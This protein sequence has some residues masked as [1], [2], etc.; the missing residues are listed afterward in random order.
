MVQITRS[1]KVYD[2][3]I[4]GSGAAGGAAAK[5][6]AE[7]GLNVVM[8]EAGP[9]LDPAKHYTEHLWPYELP[10]R[11]AGIG[12]SGFNSS[13]SYEL[14]VAYISGHIE[15]EPYSNAP[16]SEFHWT[17]GRLLGGRTNHWNCVTLRFADQDLRTHS[18]RGYG[19]DW[20]ITYEEIAPYY[21][22]VES[23]VGVYGTR[24]GI[25][26]A[27]DGIYLPPPAPRCSDRLIQRGCQKLG[28][29]CIPGRAA[30]ITR[31]HN[32][33]AACHYCAQC[34]QGCHTASRFS[35]SQVLIPDALKT[36]RLTI[37]PFAMAREVTVGKDGKANGV[38]YIDKTNRREQHVRAR[39]VVLG[40]SACESA[41][42]LL[43]SQSNLFPNGLANSSGVVG[44]Y[45]MDTSA[46]MVVGEFPELTRIPAHN[47]DGTGSVHVYI[48]FW[49][50][51][52]KLD[53]QGGYH[54]E[55]FGGPVMPK[56][57][58]FRGI[59]E[60]YGND[61]ILR[62]KQAYGSTIQMHGRGEMIPNPNSFCEI[63]TGTIDQWGIPVLRFHLQWSSN[64]IAMA[65]DMRTS[66]EE[67]IKAG[68]GN[69]LP[70]NRHET[71]G[72]LNPGGVA[73]EVGTVRMGSDPRT[74][75]LNGFCQ[76]H[77]VKN[78]FVTDGGSFTTSPD[79]NPTLTITALSWRA[80]DY[81]LEQA[82]RGE[83]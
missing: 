69:P 40:A 20:P 51:N 25:A 83:I 67:I 32:K 54:V 9:L 62:C 71:F 6:L 33:R 47:H 8:L 77:E 81:L 63:D 57:G 45:L 44:R 2:V 36:G 66:F 16:G 70:G 34:T 73:H 79:K 12:G 21:D 24:E 28:I 29:P 59:A 5:V 15:G 53:Y 46:H 48:P 31:P 3:C 68:G 80:S 72:F 14:D 30:I 17:R 58:M 74:S 65:Q 38:A 13:G 78:L 26:G 11:G 76:A 37:V 43:N 22:K 55:I 50:Q 64:E 61:L 82:R 4:V 52:R 27:P 1:P 19:E 7:G 35:S 75:V 18:L 60:G 42:L 56:A 10:H 49:K 39:A 23:F 41:R